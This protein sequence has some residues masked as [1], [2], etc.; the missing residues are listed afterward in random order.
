LRGL[1]HVHSLQA[2]EHDKKKNGLKM[3]HLAAFR[4]AADSKLRRAERVYAAMKCRGYNQQK[5]WRQKRAP[6]SKGDYIFSDGVLPFI[7]LR[8]LT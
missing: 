4:P 7:L 8:I 5:L 1:H 3:K 2:K 6:L